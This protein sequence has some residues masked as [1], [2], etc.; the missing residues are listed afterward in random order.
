MTCEKRTASFENNFFVQNDIHN[1]YQQ[2]GDLAKKNTFLIEHLPVAA[3]VYLSF[4]KRVE[5]IDM[6]TKLFVIT[7]GKPYHASS[8]ERL[9][10]WVKEVMKESGVS[11]SIYK[12]HSTRATSN[13]IVYKSG[14]PVEKV[15]KRVQ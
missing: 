1:R 2:Y 7:Y 8:K 9:P 12:G 13:A 6:D 14:V 15:L 10:R 11:T 3:S 4:I 5:I